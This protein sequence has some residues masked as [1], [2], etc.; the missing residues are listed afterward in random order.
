MD[1]TGIDGGLDARPLP[2]DSNEKWSQGGDYFGT[3][4]GTHNQANFPGRAFRYNHRTHRGHWTG[5][6]GYTIDITNKWQI[7]V[8]LNLF[9]GE[10]GHGV[11]KDHSSSLSRSSTTETLGEIY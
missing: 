1:A 6:G 4:G 10:I 11:I 3:A 2:K 9:H 8:V 7:K 5:G